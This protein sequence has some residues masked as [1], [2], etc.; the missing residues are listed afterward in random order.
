MQ[1]L[2][3]RLIEYVRLM[4]IE[5]KNIL[6]MAILAYLIYQLLK[7]VKNTRTWFL[8]RGIGLLLVFADGRDDVGYMVF[9]AYVG[10]IADMDYGPE[11]PLHSA[12]R[13]GIQ[14]APLL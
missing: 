8:L 14:P 2:L 4:Q 1:Q 6:E 7:W 12:Y 13:A 11:D 3:A 9:E 5:P 10:V